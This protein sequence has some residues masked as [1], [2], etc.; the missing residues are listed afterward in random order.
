MLGLTIRMT[1]KMR[2]TSPQPWDM[3]PLLCNKYTLFQSSSVYSLV[4]A[5][6]LAGWLAD[7]LTEKPADRQLYFGAYFSKINGQLSTDVLV[8]L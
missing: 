1:K 6:W 4:W 8:V 7:R 5:G 3:Q 2:V